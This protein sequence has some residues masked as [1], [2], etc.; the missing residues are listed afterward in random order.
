MWWSKKED[1]QQLRIRSSKV[2]MRLMLCQLSKGYSGWRQHAHEGRKLRIKTLRVVRMW[3]GCTL[4]RVLAHWRGHAAE[5]AQLRN[6]ARKVV[7]RLVKRAVVS[8]LEQWQVH[9]AE[10]R[11]LRHKAIRVVYRMLNGKMKTVLDR[12]R[13]RVGADKR[14]RVMAL[15][16]VHRMMFKTLDSAYMSW[17]DWARKARRREG[18]CARVIHHWQMRTTAMAFET[19][20]AQGREQR[21]MGVVIGRIM[22]RLGHRSL[23]MAVYSWRD[24]VVKQGRSRDI[25]RKIISHWTHRLV[26]GAMEAWVLKTK[27]Q[28]RVE[29]ICSRVIWRM[30]NGVLMRSMDCWCEHTFHG[31]EAC[32]HGQ[33]A[34][35]SVCV[36]IPGEFDGVMKTA[37]TQRSF[38]NLL[39]DQVCKVLDIPQG[40]VEVM[41]HERCVIETQAQATGVETGDGSDESGDRPSLGIA[42]R[43]VRTLSGRFGTAQDVAQD[44]AEVARQERGGIKAQ[45]VVAGVERGDGSDGAIGLSAVRLARKLEQASVDGAGAFGACGLEMTASNAMVQGVV[46]EGVVRSVLSSMTQQRQVVQVALQADTHNRAQMRGDNLVRRAIQRLMHKVG[47][48]AL[49]RWQAACADTAWQQHRSKRVERLMQL[50]HNIAIQAAGRCVSAWKETTVR[51]RRVRLKMNRVLMRIQHREAIAALMTWVENAADRRRQ[52]HTARRILKRWTHKVMSGCIERWR[53]DMAQRHNLK[54]QAAKVLYRM[55]KRQQ[56]QAFECW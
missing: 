36:M 13:E 32:N 48:K 38:D 51:D 27:Q 47:L 46:C 29:S 23:A 8:A 6:K 45:V 43:L 10:Q 2:A 18:V 5:E 7:S 50:I 22:N 24:T 56:I 17:R 31:E 12:W 35:H 40:R 55:M 37:E 4:T 30:T 9:A 11:I 14:L 33:R 54:T 53:D 1:A 39:K 42:Q 25:L 26:S 34:W 20:Q 49:M 41:S 15:R 52:K 3:I 21:R 28:A 19:W 16:I 44:N